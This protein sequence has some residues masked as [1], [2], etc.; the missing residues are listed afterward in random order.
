MS[1]NPPYRADIVGSFLRTPALAKARADR[2]AGSLDADA[3]RAV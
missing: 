3:L 1:Q 2:E